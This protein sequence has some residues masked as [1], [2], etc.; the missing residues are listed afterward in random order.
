MEADKLYQTQCREQSVTP[1]AHFPHAAH[2]VSI[3]AALDYPLAVMCLTEA[4]QL[5][6]VRCETGDL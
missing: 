2:F 4:L 3:A 6:Y 1:Y 5:V